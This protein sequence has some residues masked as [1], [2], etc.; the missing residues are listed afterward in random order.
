[1]SEET[2]GASRGAARG[3]IMSVVVSAIFGYILALGVTFA[4][5][6]LRGRPEPARS[7]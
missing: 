4:I 6:D 5:Q 3:I 7:R 1:M 2:Q